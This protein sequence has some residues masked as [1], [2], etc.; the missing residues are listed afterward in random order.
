MLLY[1]VFFVMQLLYDYGLFFVNFPET[2]QALN[3]KSPYLIPPSVFLTVLHIFM[4][5]DFIL[6]QLIILFYIVTSQMVVSF[7]VASDY[8]SP[9]YEN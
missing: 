3:T 7:I 9:P 4:G 1:I 6:F 8:I 5:G 2:W